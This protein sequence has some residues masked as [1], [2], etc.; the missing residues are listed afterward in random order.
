M[1]L[2]LKQVILAPVILA[3]LVLYAV[4]CGICYLMGYDNEHGAN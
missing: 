3:G 1:S 2:L 4:M